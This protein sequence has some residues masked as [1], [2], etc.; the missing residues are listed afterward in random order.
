MVGAAITPGHAIA[1]A[2]DRKVRGTE[3][4]CRAQGI[5]F[6]PM[7][8]ESFGGWGDLAIGVV[9]RLATSHARQ[10]ERGEEEVLSHNWGA[11]GGHPPAS[12]RPDPGKQAA[13]VYI[14]MDVVSVWYDLFTVARWLLL[15]LTKTS[16]YVEH[17]KIRDFTRTSSS[18]SP[19]VDTTNQGFRRTSSSGSPWAGTPTLDLVD[20]L[21]CWCLLV[22][23]L[24]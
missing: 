16:S 7:V 21:R 4:A 15:A 12:D 6:L 22:A 5:A 2:Y 1:F 20:G 17:N 3:E 10:T 23:Y 13:L 9:R 8:M 24:W 11:P 18:G 14:P 19:W